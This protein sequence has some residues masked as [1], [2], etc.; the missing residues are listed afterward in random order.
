[1]TRQE[2][3]TE[4]DKEG[5]SSICKFMKQNKYGVCARE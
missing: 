2:K 4:E 1:M 5:Y 3:E